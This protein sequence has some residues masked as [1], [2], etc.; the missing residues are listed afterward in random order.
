MKGQN[1]MKKN[2][3]VFFLFVS[4]LSFFSVKCLAQDST[5]SKNKFASIAEDA[6]S[7]LQDKI[8]LSDE[9]TKEVKEFIKQ[10]LENKIGIT[11]S[12]ILFSKIEPLLDSRQKDKF[13]IVKTDWLNSIIIEVNNSGQ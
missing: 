9:Q 12:E 13:E 10:S 7:K 4:I 5:S 8:L 2:L 11:N 3:I 1:L 6:A